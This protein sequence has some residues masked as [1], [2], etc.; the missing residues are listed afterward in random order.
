MK[1]ERSGPKGDQRLLLAVITLIILLDDWLIK[2]TF[3][4]GSA[5]W[6]N[7]AAPQ[8]KELIFQGEAP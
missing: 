2:A 1:N 7:P 4:S 6:S 5:T 8:K 3:V